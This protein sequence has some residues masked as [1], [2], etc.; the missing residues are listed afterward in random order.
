MVGDRMDKAAE[1][2]DAA[3]GEG[4]RIA[5][6]R[7]SSDERRRD[8]I[9]KSIELFAEDGFESSTRE[10]ARRLG[11]TQPLLYRYFPSKQDLVSAVYEEVYLRRWQPEWEALLADRSRPLRDR[12]TEFYALYTD[13]IFHPD[14]IRIYLYSGLKGEAINARYM[15]LVVDRIL[16]P[17]FAEARAEAGLPTRA[18]TDGEI[19]QIWVIHGGIFYFGVIKLVYQKTPPET[20]D[21]AIAFAV[22]ALVEGLKRGF[23]AERP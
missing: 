7:L 5:R 21:T 10:L 20:K 3:T 22:D 18:P 14:W 2:S 13:A 23:A 19:D 1:A 16:V 15:K 4:Q 17:I 9:R 12:L 8:F 11:V 6:R